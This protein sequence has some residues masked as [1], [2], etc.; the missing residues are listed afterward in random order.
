MKI[1]I[2]ED[3]LVSRNKLERLIHSLGYETLVAVDGKEALKIWRS[4]RPRIVITDWIMPKLDGIELCKQIRKAEG[5]QYTYIIMVTSK[6]DTH[7]LVESL[8]AGADDF[9][10]KPYVKEELAVR[11]R[12]GRRILDF[13]SRDTVIFPISKLAESR[14]PETGYHLERIRH[15]SQVLAETM[16][17]SDNPP[18]EIDALFIDNLFLT[19]PLHDIGKIGI[20]DHILLKPTHLDDAEFA[21]MKTHTTIGYNALNAAAER[22]NRAEYLKM[23]ASIALS[24]HEKYDGTGYPEGLKGEEI[25]LCARIVALA[26]VYDALVNKRVYKEAYTHDIAKSIILQGRGTHFDPKVVDAFLQ[27][28]SAFIEINKRYKERRDHKDSKE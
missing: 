22:D 21:I 17:K 25:P 18:P 15:Y 23:S 6:T 12:A 28:E 11:I 2:V 19:S 3:E 24:H 5:S 1:L 9:I 16:A 8:E 10:S 13:Q 20:P 4:E 26:D 7:D 27:C 14:D